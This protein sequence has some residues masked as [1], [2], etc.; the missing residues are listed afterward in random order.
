MFPTG[1]SFN[2]GNY[3]EPTC[4]NG[5]VYF[6]PVDGPIMAFNLTNGL[7]STSATS[8]SADVYNGKTN[9]FSARGGET[10]VSPNGSSNGI[11]WAL[12]S[13][14][15]KLPEHPARLQ[16]RRPDAGVLDE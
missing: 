10:A 9:T 7:L 8:Q 15:D 13:N 6:A 16:S 4:F 12:Q 2:T 5:K 14:G 1:G 3:G 11:L